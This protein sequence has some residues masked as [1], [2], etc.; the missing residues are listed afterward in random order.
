MG[1]H[2]NHGLHTLGRRLPAA[3]TD[4]V[5][6]L[7]RKEEGCCEAVE[8]QH[9]WDVVG[10]GRVLG[11]EVTV[12]VADEVVHDGV[13]NPR[14][15]EAGG[16]QEQAGAPPKLGAYQRFWTCLSEKEQPIKK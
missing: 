2:D 4:G 13:R 11:Q 6:G 8:L 16:E 5:L 14:D 3:I 7:Q 10:V 15:V 9:A 12:Q 1:G